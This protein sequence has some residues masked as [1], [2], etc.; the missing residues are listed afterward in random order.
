VGKLE[1]V[2]DDMVDD[3]GVKTRVNL[4]SDQIQG[5]FLNVAD[6]ENL[7]SLKKKEKATQVYRPNYF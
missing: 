5:K 3:G 4:I 1:D 7:F 6:E 2:D